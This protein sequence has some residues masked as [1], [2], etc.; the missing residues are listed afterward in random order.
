MKKIS[1]TL[2]ILASGFFQTT[3]GMNN[4]ET[5]VIRQNTVQ[6][7]EIRAPENNGPIIETAITSIV[8]DIEQ[9]SFPHLN[10]NGI[11]VLNEQ[12]N[13]AYR[14]LSKWQL[15][16]IRHYAV[17]GQFD[18]YKGLIKFWRF[19]EGGAFP[20]SEL[21]QLFTA[22]L[23]LL[24]IFNENGFETGVKILTTLSGILGLF[25][26]RI[27]DFAGQRIA[28][29]TEISDILAI[30]KNKQLEN[31]RQNPI[32]ENESIYQDFSSNEPESPNA[33]NTQT[34]AV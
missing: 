17:H 15:E 26:G 1:V 13:D 8:L 33:L 28:E 6:S 23:P 3:Y 5:N 34:E 31:N 7:A 24:S 25:F 12:T 29:E 30:L 16:R 14:N 20:L 4:Q 18:A 32:L 22:V 9:E 21:F 27:S 11:A 19:I 10:T 2:V